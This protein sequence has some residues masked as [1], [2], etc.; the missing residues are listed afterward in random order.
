VVGREGHAQVQP[1]QGLVERREDEC[2][3]ERHGRQ[4]ECGVPGDVG[5]R[6]VPSTSRSRPV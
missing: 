6:S 1:Q 3:R 2:V 4:E 5:E